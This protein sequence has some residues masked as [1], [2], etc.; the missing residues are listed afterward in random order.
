MRRQLLCLSRGL[1]HGI[2][3]EGDRRLEGTK[4]FAR[5]AFEPKVETLRLL[6]EKIWHGDTCDV[7]V[8]GVIAVIIF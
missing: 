6:E 1:E 3:V 5:W 2:N 8:A 7:G 4:V